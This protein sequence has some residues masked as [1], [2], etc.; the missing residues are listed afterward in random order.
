MLLQASDL[1]VRY[2]VHGDELHAV[3]GVDLKVPRGE[4]LGIVGESGCG[5]TTLTRVLLGLLPITATATGSVLLE[6]QELIGMPEEKLETVRGR[7]IALIP[8]GAMS[9]LNPVLN[10]GSQVA[11]VAII[12]RGVHRQEAGEIVGD[13]FQ[14]VGLDPMRQHHYPHEFSGGMRQRVVVAMALAGGADVLIADEP[15]TGLDVLVQ[16]QI[17]QLL[18]HLQAELGLTLLL[19]SHDLRV[20]LRTCD[21]VAVMYAGQIVESAPAA[22]IRDNPRHPYSAG[23]LAA[24]PDIGRYGTPW[25]SIPGVPP[26]LFNPPIG[27]S[28]RAR[29]EYAHEQCRRVDPSLLSQG[30]TQVKCHLYPTDE[31]GLFPIVDEIPAGEESEPATGTSVRYRHSPTTTAN[32]L[33]EIKDL[34]KTYVHRRGLGRRSAVR[35]VDGIN[36]TVDRGET[37]GLVGRSGSGKSTVARC[38]LRLVEPTSGSILLEGVDVQTGGRQAL[39]TYRRRVAMVHQDPYE[40]LHPGMRVADLVAEPLRIARLPVRRARIEEVLNACGITPTDDL[41]RRH[42]T[43]LSGGQRQRVALARALAAEPQLLLAD[44]PTS[45]LDV[46]VRAGIIATLKR[47]RDDLGLGVL[48]ITHDF[49]EAF[50]LCD[51]LVVLLEGRVVEDGPAQ[52]LALEPTHPYTCALLAAAKDPLGVPVSELAG[53]TVAGA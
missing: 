28:F 35:A 2:H 6:N 9:A 43:Q 25:T 15:T 32:H 48:L 20:I 4:T 51:R 5:K 27:C 21:R 37:V 39:R 52:Q 24:L 26:D 1:N 16:A 29:C 7:R 50:Q 14:R 33:M 40:S 8:Q 19:V 36:L 41:L 30:R 45:M 12:H 22:E 18:M 31:T 49:G 13:L 17:L 11:E 53:N 44:E 10:V 23:L 42:P 47:L 34:T 38:L 46:S 3:R